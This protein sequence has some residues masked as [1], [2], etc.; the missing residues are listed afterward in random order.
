[1]NNVTGEDLG[2]GLK[3]GDDYPIGRLELT[4]KH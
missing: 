2:S 1:M 3:A 4:S